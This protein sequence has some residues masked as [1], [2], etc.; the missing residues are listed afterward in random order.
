M[1]S[2][3]SSID[4]A[5][6]TER[7]STAP[8]CFF[9]GKLIVEEKNKAI[10]LAKEEIADLIL[11]CDG[12]KLDQGG[13]GAAVVWKEGELG[14]EWQE[15]KVS[16]GKNKEILDAKIWGISETLKVAGQKAIRTQQHL[17]VSIFCDSQTIINK[18][19]KMDSSAGQALKIQIYQKADQLTQQGHSI[20]VY[21]VPG[22]SGLEGNE[23][24]DKAAK[25][26]TTGERI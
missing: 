4:P 16:L 12:S 23:R 10:N 20:S 25:E 5:K 24:A 18:L 11:W 8:T 15:K 9:P 22:H 19:A 3:G 1:V 13:A 6:G 26:A 7:I 2:V 14:R 17:A 21:W